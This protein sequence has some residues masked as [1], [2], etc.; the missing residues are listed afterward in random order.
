MNLVTADNKKL[1]S[2]NKKNL[3]VGIWCVDNEH[4]YKKEKNKKYLISKYHWNDQI[5]FR[6]DLKY[7][8]KVYNLLLNNLYLNLNKFHKSKYP[9]RYWEIILYKWLWVYLFRVFDCWEIIR[10]IKIKN[11]KISSK[12]FLYEEKNFIPKDSDEF[13]TSMLYSEDW[14]HW[15]Y[16]KILESVGGIN[17]NYINKNKIKPKFWY[18]K[19]EYESANYLLNS[20][21]FLPTSKKIYSQNTYF[22][23][24]FEVMYR[25]F[26]RQ[27]GYKKEIQVKNLNTPLNIRGREDLSKL[28]KGDKFTK[29]AMSIIK[30]QLPKIY[31]ENFKKINELIEKSGVPKKPKII[32]TSLDHIWNDVFK[33]YSA[34]NVINDTKLYILQHGG[35]Y[36]ITDFNLDEKNELR[37]ADKFL[38]WGWKDS[39]KKALPLFLQ[40]NLYKKIKKKSNASGLVLPIMEFTILP[41]QDFLQGSPRNKIETNK[42]IDNIVSFLSLINKDILKESSFKYIIGYK[43]NYVKKS[44]KYKFP[45]LKFENPNKNTAEISENFKLVVDTVNSSGFLQSL[46]LNIPI[47]LIYDKKYS[48]LR[49]SAIKDYQMLEKAKIIHNSPQEAANFINSNYD[50]LEKWWNS[51]FLQK[52]R[53]KFCNK[54][55]KQSETPLKNLK[56]ILF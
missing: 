49:K 52:V 55:A 1:W 37:I 42:Y 45:K 29:F 13:S 22:S 48:S 27:F 47:I 25:F 33:I 10:S 34:K 15:I 5:K 50:H 20:F 41:G 39:N 16:T 35:C 43:Y 9:R 23:K 31:L 17:C 46:N 30:Y 14:N 18:K 56:K 24:E 21:S 54:Y 19:N 2:K 12:N 6:K 7:L 38:T 32:L 26:N 28:K 8:E 51:K 44:L 11:K 36:G 53:S 3:L 40:Q 4:K